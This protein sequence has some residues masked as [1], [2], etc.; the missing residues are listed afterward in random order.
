MVFEFV[1][2][3]Y[4]S[5]VMSPRYVEAAGMALKGGQKSRGP[6][7]YR[8]PVAGLPHFSHH[9]QLKQIKAE[10]S[11]CRLKATD[12]RGLEPPDRRDTAPSVN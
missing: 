12:L 8:E 4:G 7:G 3:P 1:R 6:V 10:L 9:Q 2:A 5:R 11:W